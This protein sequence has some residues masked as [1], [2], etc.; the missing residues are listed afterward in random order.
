M[1]QRYA[2]K[3]FL[4]PG[5]ANEY[6]HR[7]DA[8]WPEL[9]ALLKQAGIVNYSIHLDPETNILFA[10]LERGADHRMDELPRHEI[11]RRW[12][13]HMKDIMA[14]NPDGSP[15]SAPLVEMFH[16]P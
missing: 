5:C 12:W 6:R 3:M 16:L 9:S 11:M 10:Y 4:N 7:H 2:F 1:S 15:V 8:I 14:A 13:D